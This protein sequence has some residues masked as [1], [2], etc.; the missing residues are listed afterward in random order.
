MSLE[1]RSAFT[2]HHRTSTAAMGREFQ[3]FLLVAVAVYAVMTVG[4]VIGYLL[5]FAAECK[6][7][8]RRRLERQARPRRA[9]PRGSTGTGRPERAE[10]EEDEDKEK[11]HGHA[12]TPPCCD[13]VTPSIRYVT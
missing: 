5:Q 3:I 8:R 4:V 1:N 10:C 9:T 13:L 11:E 6:G 2:A 7:A 12:R